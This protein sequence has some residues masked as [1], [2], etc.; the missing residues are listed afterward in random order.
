MKAASKTSGASGSENR[1]SK[2]K[3]SETRSQKTQSAS[4]TREAQDA[5]ELLKADHRK[6]EGL[7]DKFESAGEDEK[8]QIAQQICR[9]LIIHTLLEEEIFYPACRQEEIEEEMMDEAQIE[10]D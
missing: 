8:K 5:D 10:H 9:E 2:T 7:F 3:A 4:A 6:V 1:K